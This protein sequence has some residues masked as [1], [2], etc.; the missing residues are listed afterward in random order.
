MANNKYLGFPFVV[1]ARQLMS[2]AFNY[3]MTKIPG[4]QPSEGQ[5]DVWMIEATAGEAADIGTLV[6][7]VPKAVFR[8]LGTIYGILP[9][10]AAAASCSSTWFLSDS[11]GHTIT[12][13]TQVAIA[14]AAGVLQPFTVLVDVIVPTGQTQTTVGQVLLVAAFP[15]AAATALGSPG[16]AV[17]LLDTI[18]WVTSITQVAATTGGSDGETDDEYLDRLAVELQ[19]ITPTP[20][21]PNDFAILARKVPGVQRAV[22]IDGYNPADD[23][24]GNEKMVTVVAMDSS[25]VGV[26]VPERAAISA[27]LESLRELNFVVNTM[28]PT[29]TLVDVATLYTVMPGFVI[30]DVDDSVA[31]T[32]ADFLNPLLWGVSQRGDDP[33]SWNNETTIGYLELATAINN[34]QGV[35]KI[36]SL[37]IGVHLDLMFA[38]DLT[39]T[40]IVPLPGPGTITASGS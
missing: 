32:I 22:A 14:D 27:Y 39:L 10:S 34:T 17:S 11:L 35:D 30:A 21:L 13:G 38:Q 16:G 3:M 5:V 2:N 1:D 12:A 31:A 7:Q 40:G 4:W 15:G 25:G 26:S 20:I 33:V 23:T 8:Y 19:T 36:T 29:V 18:E 9:E 28:D 6:S 24:F 37:L